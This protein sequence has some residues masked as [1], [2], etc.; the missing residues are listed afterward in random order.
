MVHN[1]SIQ[2]RELSFNVFIVVNQCIFPRECSFQ[3]HGHFC[4]AVEGYSV[5]MWKQ[6]KEDEDS[7]VKLSNNKVTLEGT[8][9][10]SCHIILCVLYFRSSSQLSA[11]WNREEWSKLAQTKQSILPQIPA[12][13]DQTAI[14][15]CK[16]KAAPLEVEIPLHRQHLHHFSNTPHP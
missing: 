14:D 9:K 2:S 11:C 6:G 1:L 12:V 16:A 15:T 8:E 7:K 5:K 10:P 4:R 3:I 13:S